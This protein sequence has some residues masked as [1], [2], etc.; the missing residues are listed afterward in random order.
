MR[1]DFSSN[2]NREDKQNFNGVLHQQGR[3]L[4]DRDWNAQTDILNDWQEIAGQDIIGA[5][6]AAVPFDAQNNFKVT[7]ARIENGKV[8]LQIN[9]GRVWADGLLVEMLRDGA[10]SV[11]REAEYLQPPIQNPAATVAQL[12]NNLRDAVILEVWR[13]ELNAFQNP[14]LLIEPAL[15]GVDTTERVQTAFRFRLFRMNADDNCDKIIGRLKDNFANKGKL[16]VVLQ[17]DEDVA[18]DCPVVKDGGYTGFEHQLYRIEIAQTKLAQAH[19]KW[20]QFNGGLVG[21]GRFDSV[22]RKLQIVHNLNAIVNANLSNFYLETLVFDEQRNFWTVVYGARVTLGSDNRFNLP[23]NNDAFFGTIPTDAGKIYFFRLWNDIRPIA[24]FT[25]ETHLQDGIRLDFDADAVGKYTPNDYWTFQVRAGGIEN[26]EV[27]E[28]AGKPTLIHQKPPEGIRYHRVP[29]AE[30]EW[31]NN[32]ISA[33]NGLIEDCRRIFEPLTK[34]STCCTFR[35]GDGTTTHGD[36]TSIQTAIDSLPASGGEI[37]VL[38]GEYRENI[39]LEKL[40]N[41]KIKGCGNRTKISAET[42]DPVF[43][44]LGGINIC[45]ESLNIIADDGEI[46]VLLEGD[47]IFVIAE[48]NQEKFGALRNIKLDKLRVI[49]GQQSAVKMQVGQSVS[50]TNSQ[51][52]IKDLET[53]RDFSPAVFLAGDDLLFE[54]NEIRVMTRNET[55]PGIRINDPERYEPAKFAGGGLHLAGGCER[56]R[57]I[58]NFIIGGIGNGINLGGIDEEKEEVEPPIYDLLIEHNKIFCM[59]RSGIGVDAFS[60]LRGNRGDLIEVRNLCI[61]DNEIRFCLNLPLDDVPEDV[62]RFAGFGGISLADTANPIIRDNFIT[63]NGADFRYPVCGIFI[64]HGEGIE[65]SRNRILNNGRGDEKID[66]KNYKEGLR[67][68]VFIF[69]ATAGNSSGGEFLPKPSGGSKKTPLPSGV[70]ALKMHENIV[71]STFGRALSVSASGSVSV[72]GNRFLTQRV[73]PD[74]DLATTIFISSLNKAEEIGGNL[75]S[76]QKIRKG[77][78]QVSPK[79]SSANRLES[80]TKKIAELLRKKSLLSGSILFADNQCETINAARGESKELFSAILIASLAD[81]SFNANYCNLLTAHPF[82]AQTIVFGATVRVSDNYFQEIE[83]NVKFSANTFGLLNTTTDNQ[84]THCLFIRGKVFLNRYNL[85]FIDAVSGD[86]TD[87]DIFPKRFCRK[88]EVEAMKDFG[89][90]KTRTKG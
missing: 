64:L 60:A 16:T 73:V 17:D 78:V 35:V 11:E 7:N 40:H 76:Y 13:E 20:S 38:P 23:L 44:I 86:I 45:L 12:P 21:G 77:Q 55:N 72:V 58:D 25:A 22:N 82:L 90:P 61:F 6:V 54:A 80:L 88:F 52:F 84:S 79:N 65:I 28:I 31:Q 39:R 32:Q 62:L 48:D 51:F 18:G 41:V 50:I 75:A 59:G 89:N 42:S 2:W 14:K 67:G 26:N 15:G 1:G 53:G 33:Q 74:E 87:P 24:D 8:K 57:V 3:V 46:G 63:D 9:T 47:E 85:T 30:L 70:Q 19:F 4:L 69:L 37:C 5:G 66:T 10:A 43:H 68:G 83:R 34:L 29:L 27:A 71:S 81:I 49:A 36:F 56:V